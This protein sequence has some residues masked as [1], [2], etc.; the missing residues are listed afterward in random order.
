MQEGDPH[1]TFTVCQVGMSCVCHVLKAS[2]MGLWASRICVYFLLC[3]G[4]C[5]FYQGNWWEQWF[6]PK[7]VTR[8]DSV[9]ELICEM[10]QHHYWLYSRAMPLGFIDYIDT[11]EYNSS[12]CNMCTEESLG[13]L[14]F[15]CVQWLTKGTPRLSARLLLWWAFRTTSQAAPHRALES[16]VW[17]ALCV[18]GALSPPSVVGAATLRYTSHGLG[19]QTECYPTTQLFLTLTATQ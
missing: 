15:S 14:P 4:L 11:L 1:P 2:P 9:P 7:S 8:S 19:Q 5:Y 12:H 13:Q 6:L 18:L 17:V 16:L 10:S 3:S